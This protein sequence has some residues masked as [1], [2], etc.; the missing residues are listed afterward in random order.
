[1]KPANRKA[2][3]LVELLVVISIIAILIAILLPALSKARE[4][5]MLIKDLSNAR[6]WG[7]A[8]VAFAVDNDGVLP[9]GD[10][11]Q[12]YIET[13]VWFNYQ[14]WLTL[15]EDYGLPKE[16][17]RCL[18]YESDDTLFFN[19]RHGNQTWTDVGWIYYANRNDM[20]VGTTQDGENYI[21][22]KTTEDNQATSKTLLTCWHYDGATVGRP[23]GSWVPH[24]NDGWGFRGFDNASLGG[25][26]TKTGMSG[27]NVALIDGSASWVPYGD[28]EWFEQAEALYFQPD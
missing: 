17:S 28:L 23:W 13:W 6:Q 19:D 15:N 2:F 3:T 27:L 24:T 22:P 10:T 8:S 20:S 12:N 14:S 1:M 26:I 11:S 16:A 9:P 21:T 7:M 4:T 5:G 18:G 25:D